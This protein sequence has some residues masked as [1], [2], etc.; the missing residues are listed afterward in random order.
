MTFDDL[1]RV[2]DKLPQ[3]IARL[4]KRSFICYVIGG[5]LAAGTHLLIVAAAVE[6]AGAGV[7][8]ANTLGFV[9]GVCINYNFQRHVTFRRHA[10][11][12]AEQMPLFIGFAVVGLLINRFVY[13]HGRLDFHLHYLLAAACAILVVFVFNYV[14]NSLIT[15]KPRTRGQQIDIDVAQGPLQRSA[16]LSSSEP[17]V[18]RVETE[19]AG[20]SYT[21]P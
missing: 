19:K 15:F 6:L 21:D 13:E 20:G 5:C 18:A 3:P 17:P 12:H 16:A 14:A 4:L 2:V 9:V 1:Q 11:S 10:R 7:N 8:T